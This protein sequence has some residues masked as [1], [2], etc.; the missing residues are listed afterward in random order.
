[1]LKALFLC[2]STGTLGWSGKPENTLI[3]QWF[4]KWEEKAAKPL[5]RI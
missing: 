5:T 3:L 2:L 1:M 4:G